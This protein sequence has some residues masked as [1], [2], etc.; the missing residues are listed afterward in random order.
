MAVMLAAMVLAWQFAQV[1]IRDA[2]P[3]KPGTAIISGHVTDKETGLPLAGIV[4][5]F[6]QKRVGDPV[7]EARTDADGFYQ[8]ARAP[9]GSHILVAL[10]P[11]YRTTHLPQAYGDSDRPRAR[12]TQ[13]VPPRIEIKDGENR[14]GL[15]FALVRALGVS[16]A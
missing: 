5:R 12:W 2:L 10:M 8:I 16:G 4:I 13:G 7:L 1:P 15:D 6:P 3:A 14:T 11:D 9:A